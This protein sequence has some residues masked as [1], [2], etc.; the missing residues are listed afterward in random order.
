[1]G[2]NFRRWLSS[3]IENPGVLVLRRS[4]KSIKDRLNLLPQIQP[5]SHP[6]EL[7]QRK[8][9]V[10]QAI[11]ARKTEKKQQVE[12]ALLLISRN[13]KSSKLKRN[14]LKKEM[15]RQSDSPRLKT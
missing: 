2:S 14:A 7:I 8:L 12:K 5:L 15:A 9:I 6:S 1:M 3:T 10:Q 4:N 11:E 13:F